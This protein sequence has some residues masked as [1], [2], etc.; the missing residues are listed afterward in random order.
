LVS[1]LLWYFITIFLGWITFPLTYSL[2]TKLADRGYTLARIFGLM[3]WGYVFWLSAS[4]GFVKN[5]IAGLSFY[6]IVVGGLG[7]WLL[8]SSKTE[9]LGWVDG[10]KKFIITTEVLFLF[11]FVLFAFFRSANPEIIG[12]EK[13]MEL[14]FINGIINSSAFPPRDLWL[15]GYSISYYYFGYVI[16][17]MLAKLT[18]TPATAAF[19]LMLSLIFSLSAIGAYGLLYNFLAIHAIEY[20]PL[21]QRKPNITFQALLGPFFLL[22]IS[23]VEGF[24]EILHTR[25]LFW[26]PGMNFWTWLDIPELREAP[27]PL[28]SL[29]PQRLG[30]WWW[31]ASRVIM[32]YDFNNKWTG[33]VINEFPA[34]SFLLGDL[35]PHVISIPFFLLSIGTAFNLYRGGFHGEFN[36]HI[37]KFDI[38]KKGFLLS[39]IIVGGIAFLN[40]WDVLPIVSLLV[41]SYIFSRGISWKLDD[42]LNSILFGFLV[43]FA[44]F[45]LYFPFFI[46]FNSQAGGI[47]PN[48]MYITRGAQLW[49]MWGTLFIPI[50]TL[51]LYFIKVKKSTDWKTAW[52][53]TLGLLMFLSFSTLGVGFIIYWLHPELANLILASQQLTLGEFLLSSLN[54][55]FINIGS[56]ITILSLLVLTLA[57]LFGEGKANSSS[58]QNQMLWFIFLLIII[59]TLLI[60][61]PEFLYLKDNFGYRI[62]TIFKFYYQAWTMLSIVAA[63]SV[64]TLMSYLKGRSRIFAHLISAVV[65]IVGLAYPMLAFPYKANN[66][67]PA[68]GFYLDDFHRIQRE[69]PDE[70]AAILWLQKA[71]DGVIVEATGGPYSNFGRISMYTGLPTVL[72]WGN[73]EGQWRGAEFQNILVQ[74]STDIETLYS[75][76]NWSITKIIL[77]RY[78]IH[79]I[80]IGHLER[81]SYRVMEEKFNTHLPI[82][83]Q[84]GNV[85]IYEIP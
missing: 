22:V 55:R 2:F 14:M 19:N 26:Q 39:A 58:K 18:Y 62:N 60:L 23:N 38:S 36:I 16:T 46:G 78:D 54:R 69:T 73:H 24:L 7:V 53:T 74:R 82:G 47:L 83:F 27:P 40:T 63:F 66:F 49:V 76:S 13:P 70:A 51:L 41:L 72:G 28:T 20:L 77:D 34:F 11:S 6:L 48:F 32:D 50:F 37:A 43:L 56:L 68:F 59:G 65:F 12:T 45:I 8:L 57:F 1:I 15:S 61:G 3:L 75:T 42:F 35:H 71:P 30:W 81:I 64:A 33:D 9:I 85:I 4:L 79:Y 5:D 29:M 25:G 52:I 67:K 10:N 44:A 21:T 17:A 84:Q 31:R 80:V